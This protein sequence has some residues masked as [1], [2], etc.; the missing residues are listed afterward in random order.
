[1]L[2]LCICLY[3]GIFLFLQSISPGNVTTELNKRM[4]SKDPELQAQKMVPEFREMDAEDIA[5]AVVYALSSPA[6]VQVGEDWS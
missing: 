4:F 3:Q 1:M 5:D 2:F 6:H